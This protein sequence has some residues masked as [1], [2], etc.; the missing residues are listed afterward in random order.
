MKFYDREKETLFLQKVR[1][2]AKKHACFTILKG[3][4]RLFDEAMR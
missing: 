4:R 3:R 2:K 1:E